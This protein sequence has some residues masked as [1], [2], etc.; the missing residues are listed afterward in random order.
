MNP[1]KA[2][3]EVSVEGKLNV[4]EGNCDKFFSIRTIT[5]NEH[6]SSYYMSAESNTLFGFGEGVYRDVFIN[7]EWHPYKDAT[8][9]N[10]DV[11]MV[12]FIDP[13]DYP[14]HGKNYIQQCSKL[15][16][17]VSQGE[18]REC[19][20]EIPLYDSSY[21]KDIERVKVS[22]KL[23][24]KVQSSTYSAVYTGYN[25]ATGTC[26][27]ISVK[28]QSI[29][30]ISKEAGTM[31]GI[32]KSTTTCTNQAGE[33]ISCENIDPCNSI[34]DIVR[35]YWKYVMIAIPIILMLLMSLDFFKAMSSND[36]DALKK[37]SSN[38][39]KRVVITIIILALPV[40]MTILFDWIGIRI[41]L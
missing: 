26:E 25:P 33:T 24:G 31:T 15:T 3:D 18:K 10:Q 40:L 41:C 39:V 32:V 38:A 16:V 28:P 12:Y 4:I 13:L 37:A 23:D 34:S 11:S 6:D 1:V 27:D 20:A 29:S 22:L 2:E 14:Q 35:N 8:F 21:G 17:V 30:V 7:G 19:V 36:S 5:Y 9:D